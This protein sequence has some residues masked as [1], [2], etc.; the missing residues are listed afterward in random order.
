MREPGELDAGAL[1][2]RVEAEHLDPCVERVA[3]A[4]ELGLFDRRDPGQQLDRLGAGRLAALHAQDRGEI[5]PQLVALVERLEQARDAQR[6]RFGPEQ[7][8]E[9]LARIFVVLRAVNDVLEQVGR[10]ARVVQPV[11]EQL[12]APVEQPELARRIR[13]LIGDLIG[14]L[15]EQLLELG[16]AIALRVQLIERGVGG[17]VVGVE[18]EHA[19][20]GSG[21]ARRV[22]EHFLF[23]LRELEQRGQPHR[24]VDRD[25]GATFEQRAQIR[26]PRVG[27][28]HRR[29]RFER[30]GRVG[31][32]L[33]YGDPGLLGDD[34]ITE[35]VTGEL[36]ELGRDRSNLGRRPILRAQPCERG[37]EVA[38][39]FAV[40]AE[41]AGEHAERTAHVGIG[42]IGGEHAQTG[43]PRRRRIAEIDVVEP[44]QR[45]VEL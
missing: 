34:P 5:L 1:V 22:A 35:P 27:A 43:E 44:H 19:L 11:R 30:I 29:E 3:R 36:R 39:P 20:V 18:V 14:V 9:Q 8:L 40:A 33:E 17:V 2:S 31:L 21:R 45:A 6:D 42:G 10:P 15:R 4:G 28:I 25:V 24:V 23:E 38:R 26:P 12:G 32:D 37:R 13:L 7:L 16:P 41:L